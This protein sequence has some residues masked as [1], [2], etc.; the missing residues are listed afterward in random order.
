[1]TNYKFFDGSIDENPRSQTAYTTA[2]DNNQIFVRRAHVDTT[3]Q[4]L[5]AATPDIAQVIPV[6]INEVIL[7]VWVR[8]ET[9]E[10]TASAEFSIG[11]DAV[12]NQFMDDVV[13]AVANTVSSE[14]TEA[15][16]VANNSSH[17]T[18]VP[19]NS[20]DLDTGVIEVCALISKSFNKDGDVPSPGYV[21]P[22]A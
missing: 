19:S 1:M 7:G 15:V 3:K 5:T 10:S 21:H 16:H 20:V 18:L 8:I 9:I 22:L 6:A 14:F 12:N 17:I 11:F 13:V 2:G 4:T